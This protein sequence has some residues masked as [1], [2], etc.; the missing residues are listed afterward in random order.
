MATSRISSQSL[1]TALGYLIRNSIHKKPH[2]IAVLI[3]H[4]DPAFVRFPDALRKVVFSFKA[5]SRHRSRTSYGQ[6][7]ASTYSSWLLVALLFSPN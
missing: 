6:E 4:A 3:S 7:R 1:T 2:Q 5:F